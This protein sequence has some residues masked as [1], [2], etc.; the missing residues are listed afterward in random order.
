MAGIEGLTAVALLPSLEAPDL[1]A[2]PAGAL[3]CDAPL[4][5]NHSEQPLAV[6]AAALLS[7]SLLL[8]LL[9]SVEPTPQLPVPS[10]VILQKAFPAAAVHSL[11]V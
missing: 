8:P 10:L 11:L 9:L 4:A 5:Q 7:L 3:L 6:E 1:R 2:N